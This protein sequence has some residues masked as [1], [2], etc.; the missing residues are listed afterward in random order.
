M[1]RKQHHNAVHNWTD[2]ATT[3]LPLALFRYGGVRIYRQTQWRLFIAGMSASVC[4]WLKR[5]NE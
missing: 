3:G 5:F 2:V 1:F 4:C